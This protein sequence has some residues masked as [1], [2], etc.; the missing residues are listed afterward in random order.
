MARLKTSTS[1]GEPLRSREAGTVSEAYGSHIVRILE[2][3]W[4]EL[5]RVVPDIPAVVLPV[6]APRVYS[7]RGHFRIDAWRDKT[8]A[9]LLHEVAVHPGMFSAPE[10][11]LATLLPRRGTRHPLGEAQRHRP[12]LLWRLVSWLL[13]PGGVPLRR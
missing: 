10:D 7:R 4:R 5:R 9:G 3:A 2:S 6:L 11:L 12:T 13:S 8:N 1:P